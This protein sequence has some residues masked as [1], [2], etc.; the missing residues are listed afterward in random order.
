MYR[1]PSLIFF[2]FLY[3]FPPFTFL[4]PVQRIMIQRDSFSC[5]LSA[6]QLHPPAVH[7]SIPL[8]FPQL[9]F[10]CLIFFFFFLCLQPLPVSRL[11]SVLLDRDVL[12]PQSHIYLGSLRADD[13]PGCQ[14][15]VPSLSSG[16]FCVSPVEDR[17]V[18]EVGGKEIGGRC[19]LTWCSSRAPSSPA[20]AQRCVC[21]CLSA[22]E[23]SHGAV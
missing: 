5:P 2:P 15:A 3:V 16:R 6:R 20:A 4:L 7:F 10:S 12:V 18:K 13:I 23:R 19:C 9:F 11:L 21:G 17:S 22:L 1:S 8:L 14:C